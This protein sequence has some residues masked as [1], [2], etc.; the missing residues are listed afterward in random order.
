M[1]FDQMLRQGAFPVALEITPPRRSRPRVL[2]RRAT[3]LGDAVQA[4]NVIHRPDRQSSLEASIELLAHAVE[5]V[6]HLVVRGRSQAEIDRDIARA[7]D[8][9]IRQVLCVRGEQPAA[10]VDGPTIRE[11]IGMVA[12]GIPG[13]LVG[14]TLNQYR[15]TPAAI[16]NLAGKLA[17]GAGY[18]QT[19]PVFDIPTFVD[20]AERVR[21]V[22]PGVRLVPMVMPLLSPESLDR[23][24]RRLGIPLPSTLRRRVEAGR[25]EAWDAFAELVADLRW[26]PHAQGLAI[27]TF[28]TDP[29]PEDGTHIAAALHAAT[30]PR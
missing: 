10:G 24:G 4:V 19:Q 13:A 16:R 15:A 23:I 1:L 7:R 12:G 11:A 27:M 18:V 9:G 3:L 6:W 17:A 14:A 21:D 22:A 30:S 28:E 20:A 8:G 26:S 2:L 29:P 5:P 25:D